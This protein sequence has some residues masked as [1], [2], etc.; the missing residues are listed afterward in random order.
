[1]KIPLHPKNVDSKNK[2]Q[3]RECI[4]DQIAYAKILESSSSS[5]FNHP[6]VKR[7]HKE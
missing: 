5:P 3:V 1:M 4:K 6:L 2:K 7:T